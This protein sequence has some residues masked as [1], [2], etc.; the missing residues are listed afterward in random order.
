MTR[1]RIAVVSGPTATILNS[2]PLGWDDPASPRPEV[3][4]RQRLAAPVRVYVEYL[5]AHPMEADAADTY[6]GPDGYVAPDGTFAT[7]RTSPDEVPVLVATLL[8]GHLYELPYAARRADP[9]PDAAPAEGDP[10]QTFYPDA[11]RVYEEIDRFALDADGRPGMLSRLAECEHFRAAPS[12][13]YRRLLGDEVAG[14]DYFPY[15]PFDRRAEPD[16][17]ALA[18]LT[19]TVQ[20]LVSSGNY[21][22]IQYL[23]GS[24]SIEETLYWLSL[25][26]DTDKPIVGHAAQIPHQVLGSD[27]PK[28]IVDGVKYIASRA[29]LDNR[30]IDRAGPV[31]VVDGLAIA[32]REV[33]KTDSRVGGYAATGG[34]GGVVAAVEGYRGVEVDYVSGR[35]HTHRSE[36][37]LR[38]LPATI[39]YVRGGL[40]CG[41]ET[42]TMTPVGGDGDLLG[43]AIPTVLIHKSSRFNGEYG[44][45]SKPD[46]DAL[47]S[48]VAAHLSHARSP[49]G[50][51]MEGNPSYAAGEPWAEDV[52]RTAVY[53]GVP[54]VRCSRGNG[55]GFVRG[56]VPPFIAAGNLTASKARILLMAALLRYGSLTPAADPLSPTDDDI[57]RSLMEVARFQ[58]IFDSH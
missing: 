18:G 49:L 4:R 52:L 7:E 30:G 45:A 35:R 50:I 41:I 17:N 55:T 56:A 27:G 12:A 34:L 25:V 19:N 16:R 2:P 3:L 42:P 21:D 29:S 14:Q 31:L 26:I 22:G 1:V 11:S 28:N 51:T 5:S 38:R 32:A 46:R 33:A 13:G 43:R 24:A 6:L 9:P 37:V 47:W 15:M 36:L 10:R 48:F 53:C 44:S 58:Q 23:E 20:R 40:D 39:G 57:E 8:A 54:V